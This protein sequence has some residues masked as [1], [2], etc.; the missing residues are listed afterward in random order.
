MIREGAYESASE[1]DNLD[2]AAQECTVEAPTNPPT[3]DINLGNW[4]RTEPKC[5]SSIE[6]DTSLTTGK[7]SCALTYDWYVNMGSDNGSQTL[8]STGTYADG[9][10]QLGTDYKLTLLKHQYEDYDFISGYVRITTCW[11]TE[12]VADFYIDLQDA[13]TIPEIT[14]NRSSRT[15]KR[16]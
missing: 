11:G 13:V 12:G 5:Q 15:I 2:N 6:I 9:S 14:M 16:S 4:Y 8:S 1:F 3:L 7:G 10:P